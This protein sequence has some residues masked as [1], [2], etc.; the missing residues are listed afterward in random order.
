VKLIG[1]DLEAIKCIISIY[2]HRR[3]TSMLISVNLILIQYV[4]EKKNSQLLFG[5]VSSNRIKRSKFWRSHLRNNNCKSGSRL[6]SPVY[7]PGETFQ[8]SYFGDGQNSQV[9]LKQ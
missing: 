8:T 4:H 6:T 1:S 7:A 9:D 3:A 5:I 2:T